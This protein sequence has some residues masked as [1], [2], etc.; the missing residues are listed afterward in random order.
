MCGNT[1][2]RD[3]P[4]AG[5]PSWATL[6]APKGGRLY[7]EETTSGAA[8]TSPARS[9]F[10]SIR[11]KEYRQAVGTHYGP[12][13]IHQADY[14]PHH[15]RDSRAGTT[16]LC[17]L[18]IYRQTHSLPVMTTGRTELLEHGHCRR[19]L[20]GSRTFQGVWAEWSSGRTELDYTAACGRHD[21]ATFR[22]RAEASVRCTLLANV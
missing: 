2:M 11:H 20:W 19:I 8:P 15:Q 6:S 9:G 13:L 21:H 5:F 16:I 18:R 7:T 1:S 4:H 3:G 10:R 14:S 12:T 17:H 22:E